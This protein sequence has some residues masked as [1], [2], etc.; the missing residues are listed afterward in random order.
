MSSKCTSIAVAAILVTAGASA[1]AEPVQWTIGAGGNDHWYEIVSVPNGPGSFRKTWTDARVDALSRAHLGLQGYLATVTSGAENLFL[2]GLSGPF[3]TSGGWLGGNDAAVEGEWRWIDGPE[4]GQLFW[5]GDSTGSSPGYANWGAG[6]PNQEDYLEFRNDTWASN[7][8]STQNFYYIEYS[9]A[10][11]VNVPTP[12]T[13]SL[14]TLALAATGFV[15]RR[16]LTTP[17][18]PR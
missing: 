10:P 9:A 14:V 6:W 7:P 5:L 18:S 2:N 12:G 16:R 1:A 3:G 13:L 4:A 11:P 17:G 15:R 8:D